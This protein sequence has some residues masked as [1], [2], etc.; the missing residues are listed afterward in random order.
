[1]KP[2]L[3]CA[4]DFGMA[5]GINAGIIELAQEGRLSAVSCMSRGRY[6]SRDAHDL[7]GIPVETGLHLNMT[8]P[9][10]GKEFYQPLSRLLLNCY[11]RRIDPRIIIHEIE[12]QLDAYEAAFGK[13]P[14]YVDGHQHVHQFPLI[15]DCL[16]DTLLR[17]Y[18][19]HLPWLRSTLPGE[20]TG[21][22]LPYRMK[23]KLICYLGGNAL[24]NL[25]SRFGFGMNAHLLGVYD[26][27]GGEKH[28][29]ELLE[30]WLA[31]ARANDLIMCHPAK[32]AD[33]SDALGQQRVAEYSVLSGKVF[34]NLLE[35]YG[36]F[37]SGNVI[38]RD[39]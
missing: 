16:V 29:L 13:A 3:F 25:A 38:A 14:D 10:E 37:L 8:E 12:L 32:T 9:L 17:R 5:P 30:N 34:P 4:D 15:R 22:P 18:P 11:L 24:S 1:M 21:I 23:A 20:L 39:E 27:T 31:G 6:C 35:R 36:F 7:A 33:P 26:F 28:Y 2:I 19:G